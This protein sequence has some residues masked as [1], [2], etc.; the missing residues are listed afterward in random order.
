MTLPLLSERKGL[1]V[2]DIETNGLYDYVDKFWCMWAF[3]PATKEWR[4]FR[5]DE[6]EEACKFLSGFK[7]VVGHNM[8]DYDLPTMAKLGGLDVKGVRVVDTLI[9]SRFLEPDRFGGHSLKAWGKRLGNEKDSYGEE[10]VNAWDK[11]SEEMYV[12]CKQD[13]DLTYDLFVE[14]QKQMGDSLE[15]PEVFC[16]L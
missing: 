5:P 2:F 8:L 7:Y 10:T 1:V 3:V 14:L 9:I 6:L 4:G 12:Y 16:E 13:V 11:F 15:E